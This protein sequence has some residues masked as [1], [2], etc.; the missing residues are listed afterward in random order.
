MGQMTFNFETEEKKPEKKQD[1]EIKE[2]KKIIAAAMLVKT[3]IFKQINGYDENF[4]LYYED[5]DFF[6]K[7]NLLKLK[8]YF[9]TSSIFSHTK[10]QRKLD[11]L[12]LP[13]THFLNNDEKTSTFIVGGWHGQW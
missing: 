3:K 11:T 10:Y 4:F 8:L 7:C 1:V 2:E 6:R 12:N 13:S 5:N 9:V